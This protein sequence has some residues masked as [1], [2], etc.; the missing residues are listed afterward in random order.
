MP[1]PLRVSETSLV[2]SA[3]GCAEYAEKLATTGETPQP[4]PSC[5]PSTAAIQVSL[6]DAAAA[7]AAMASRM[8]ATATALREAADAYA[9]T[10]A[11]GA[12]KLGGQPVV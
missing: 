7:Q 10:D 3:A 11:Q 1:Q 4:G 6:S 5:Q 12:A 2:A 8:R 9:D